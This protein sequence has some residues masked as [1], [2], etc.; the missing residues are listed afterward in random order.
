M[1]ISRIRRYVPEHHL[2]P[3]RHV[4]VPRGHRPAGT[5]RHAR[6]R[7]GASRPRRPLRTWLFPSGMRGLLPRQGEEL[8]EPTQW[9]DRRVLASGAFDRFWAEYCYL[10]MDGE[11]LCSDGDGWTPVTD[12]VIYPLFP[13]LPALNPIFC[14]SLFCLSSASG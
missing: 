8:H 1:R 10:F 5:L 6:G 12:C 2:L 7:G 14:H 11:W 9:S 13:V 4:P 3:P